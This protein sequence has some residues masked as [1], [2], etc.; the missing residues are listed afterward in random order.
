MKSNLSMKFQ[1]QVQIINKYERNIYQIYNYYQSSM[2]FFQKY[3]YLYYLQKIKNTKK[4]LKNIN[5][6]LIYYRMKQLKI[7]LN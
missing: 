1:Q 6:R 7:N 2:Y 3:K 5:N 4:Q